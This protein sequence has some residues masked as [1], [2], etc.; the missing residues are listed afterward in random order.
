VHKLA[1][2]AIAA[3]AGVRFDGSTAGSGDSGGSSGGGGVYAEAEQESEPGAEPESERLPT[4]VVAAAA[5]GAAAAGAS[6]GLGCGGPLLRER[7][8]DVCSAVPALVRR[9][10]RSDVKARLRNAAKARRGGG[11]AKAKRGGGAKAGAASDAAGGS[12]SNSDTR[13]IG[14]GGDHG[15]DDGGTWAAHDEYTPSVDS[16]GCS[17]ARFA[18][19][20]FTAVTAAAVVSAGAAG[21]GLTYMPGAGAGYD[22]Y[23][24]YGNDGHGDGRVEDGDEDHGG[25]FGAAEHLGQDDPVARTFFRHYP[26]ED[27]SNGHGVY[28]SLRRG[29]VHGDGG[30]GDHAYEDTESLYGR[31]YRDG[32]AAAAAAGGDDDD[33]DNVDTGAVAAG[34]PGLWQSG[35]GFFTGAGAAEAVGRMGAA[36]AGYDAYFGTGMRGNGR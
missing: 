25:Y 5:A 36:G 14:S 26:G 33:G 20:A 35:D 7:W 8:P 27:H 29:D 11:G 10:P 24:D 23:G 1:A 13:V 19:V 3:G 12:S 4:S 17:G 6:L 2:L 9:P 31:A 15:G 30:S 32:Y 34:D 21:D 18:A 16:A 28:S 22:A